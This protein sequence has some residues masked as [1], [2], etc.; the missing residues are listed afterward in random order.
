MDYRAFHRRRPDTRDM[1][2]RIPKQIHDAMTAH[3][4]EGL[5]NEA[6]GFLAGRDQDVS[7]IFLLTNSAASPVFYRPDDRE[8]IAAMNEIDDKHLELSA[9]FHSHVASPAYP[10]LTDVREAHYPD[11]VYI[12]VSLVDRAAPEVRGFLIEKKDWT[13]L[14]GEVSEVELVLS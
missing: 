5:P 14:S 10:S 9:I 12:I 13:D 6:C 4:I 3:C 8:M 7:E 1:T 11:A 2:L